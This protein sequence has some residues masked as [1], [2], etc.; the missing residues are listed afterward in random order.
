[1]PWADEIL[2]ENQPTNCLHS[3]TEH[4]DPGLVGRLR[5]L[6]IIHRAGS[7]IKQRA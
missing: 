7:T 1:M 5:R 3:P 2:K 6:S 4:Q